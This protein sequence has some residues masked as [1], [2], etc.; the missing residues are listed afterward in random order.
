MMLTDMF[1]SSLESGQESDDWSRSKCILL[2]NK[3]SREEFGNDGPVGLT[4]L[5]R[6]C[7]RRE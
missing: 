4:S 5:V 1:H 7:W 3:G 2:F 6:R